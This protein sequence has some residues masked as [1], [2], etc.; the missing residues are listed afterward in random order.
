M[1]K[2]WHTPDRDNQKK[3]GGFHTNV[4]Q[5]SPRPGGEDI[6]IE[7]FIKGEQQMKASTR[8]SDQGKSE[9]SDTKPIDTPESEN[10]SI[11]VVIIATHVS[12]FLPATV[13]VSTV[14]QLTAMIFFEIISGLRFFF[15]K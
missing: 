6:L 11:Y 5:I 15:E 14:Q 9:R 1:T 12:Q 10:H 4:E 3:T 2:T 7:G 8:H 13:D